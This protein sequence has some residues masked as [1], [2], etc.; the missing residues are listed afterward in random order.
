MV[1]YGKYTVIGPAENKGKHRYVVCECQCG[2]IKTVRLS[3]LTAGKIVSCGCHSRACATTQNNE[4][5]TRLYKIWINML[6]R[7]SNPKCDAYNNYGGRGITVSTTW[8]DF[9]NFKR[10]AL[11]TGYT[12]NVTI[13][14]IDVDIGYSPEN[15]TWVPKPIQAVNRRKRAGTTSQFIGV[16][17]LK[18]GWR[19]AITFRGQSTHIGVF[20]TEIEAARA[21]DAYILANKLPHKLNF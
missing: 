20:P 18:T 8:G 10:W 13:E 12:D 15:C 17:P 5:K 21:R 19:A 4:S 16:F 14:R 11:S 7:C 6:D 9:Q 2:N 3:H 1:S